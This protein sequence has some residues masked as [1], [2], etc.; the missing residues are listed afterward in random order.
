L[1]PNF[2]PAPG[3]AYV[4]DIIAASDCVLGKIGYGSVSECLVGRRPL[5]FVRRDNFNEEPWLR[6]LLHAHGAALEIPQREFL[7][8]N[9]AP[10]L[11]RA[12][13]DMTVTFEC[14]LSHCH[15]TTPSSTKLITLYQA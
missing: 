13:N 10:Y 14:A 8:G 9:W 11:Q 1:P 2:L 3:D 15:P 5:I 4:P 7:S 6:R 12:A